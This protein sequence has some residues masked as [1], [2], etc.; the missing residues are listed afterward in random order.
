MFCGGSVLEVLM[1]SEALAQRFWFWRNENSLLSSILSTIFEDTWQCL[2]H[3]GAVDLHEDGLHKQSISCTCTSTDLSSLT[4]TPC[5]HC[6]RTQV[7]FSKGFG[8]FEAKWQGRVRTCQFWE[9]CEFNAVA[10]WD[11]TTY[12]SPN[13]E[14]NVWSSSY[15]S[16]LIYNVAVLVK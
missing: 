12:G 6:S 13:I 1:E 8:S 7:I 2:Q 5:N 4:T 15:S 3:E 9:F 10:L 11:T 14:N 16:I